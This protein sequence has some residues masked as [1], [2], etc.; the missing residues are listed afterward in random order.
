M[1]LIVLLSAFIAV[2][3][4]QA[5][6]GQ[7]QTAQEL[8]GANANVKQTHP[9]K[10]PVTVKNNAGDVNQINDAVAPP[11]TES[12][13]VWKKVCDAFG[14]VWKKTT[15][16]FKSTKVD[17]PIS[18][19]DDI[20]AGKEFPV[21]FKLKDGEKMK[22]D[23]IKAKFFRNGFTRMFSRRKSFKYFNAQ[24]NEDD[25]LKEYKTIVEEC[26]AKEDAYITLLKA[27]SRP[28]SFKMNLYKGTAFGN[29]IASKQIKVVP[30]PTE[31]ATVVTVEGQN[32][33]AGE[34]APKTGADA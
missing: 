24:Q 31:T 2:L 11:A 33:G 27:P 21:C 3:Q 18:V 7:D 15:G 4:V 6:S 34:D 14:C 16:L 9:E 26:F 25:I 12:K 5:M 28:G 13:G 22:N 30:K 17:E 19:P 8:A 29:L 20:E 23:K 10:P 1:N 32:T